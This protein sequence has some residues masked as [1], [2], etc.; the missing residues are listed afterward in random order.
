MAVGKLTAT[1][2]SRPPLEAGASAVTK[3]VRELGEACIICLRFNK[4]EEED[5][6]KEDMAEATL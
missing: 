5:M 4:A 6:G 3:A 2:V 1:S